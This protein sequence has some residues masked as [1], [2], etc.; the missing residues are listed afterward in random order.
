MQGGLGPM[1]GQADWWVLFAAERDEAALERYLR[2]VQRLYAVM[3]RWAISS[4]IL[5]SVSGVISALPRGV[6]R[7]LAVTS[8]CAQL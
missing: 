5:F 1:Q 2:E 8:W 3:D 6:Q 7:L 4:C